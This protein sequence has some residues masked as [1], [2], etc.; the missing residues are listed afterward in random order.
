VQGITSKALENFFGVARGN[1]FRSNKEILFYFIS[2]FVLVFIFH[3]VAQL[4]TN[5]NETPHQIQN[6]SASSYIIKKGDTLWDLAFTFLGDPFMW[7]E[8]WHSNQYIKNPNL[9]YPGDSLAIS[10]RERVASGTNTTESLTSLSQPDEKNIQTENDSRTVASASHGNAHNSFSDI[11]AGAD[12]LIVDKSFHKNFISSE[13]V[14]QAGFLWFEKDMKGLIYPGRAIIIKPGPDDQLKNNTKDIYRQFDEIL[15]SSIGKN[16]YAIGDTVSIMHSDR[17]VKF[18]GKTGN[19]VRRTALARITAVVGDSANAILFKAWDIVGAGDRIDT[20]PHLQNCEIDT[21]VDCD[22]AIKGTVFQRIEETESPYLFHT[23]LSDC[24]AHDGVRFGDLFL[25]YPHS[26]LSKSLKKPNALACAINIGERSCTLL[27][28]KL[29]DNSLA[30]GDTLE[31]VK[32][33]RF[34]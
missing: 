16:P 19:I 26:G 13:L 9:I 2:S 33:L 28:E 17:L 12:S 8:L 18:Q 7:P 3:S 5:Q 6:G 32:R 30:P 4:S 20:M 10:S 1:P 21:V 14:Q 15:I 27:I 25:V 23:F 24:G 34:K 22:N 29:F 31:I 11:M